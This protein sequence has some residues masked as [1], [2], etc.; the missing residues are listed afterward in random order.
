MDA[1]KKQRE[2]VAFKS[3]AELKR[4]IR[5][6]VEFKTVSQTNHADMV[7]L[8]RVVTT[9][10]TVGFYSKIKDQPDHKWS[11]CNQGM[12][13]WSPFNKAGAYHFTDSTVQVL[14]TRKNDGSVLYEMELY[15]GE[16]SMS[17]Q[18]KEVTDMNEWDRLHRQAQRYKEA[19]PPGTRIMLLG[20]G[21]DPNPVESSTRGTVR[22]VDDIG[23]LHCD[24]DNG[25]SLG[26][27]PGEDSFRMLTDEELAE[28]QN[29]DMDE[30][31]SGPVMGM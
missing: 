25:R 13:F 3:L 19:Y 5:P 8:T 9:V 26:V 11:T 17:E 22:V 10:Q 27:V 21:N 28:E 12:G 31:E 4:F 30:D 20:M 14:N 2:P 29:A 15:D 7:G 18:N 1:S 23:T 24:F 16:Q 6:G